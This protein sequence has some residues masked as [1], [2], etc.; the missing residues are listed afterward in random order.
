MQQLYR[1]EYDLFIK[2]C[3]LVLCLAA[4]HAATLKQTPE[5]GGGREG[6]ATQQQQPP[7]IKILASPNG[8]QQTVETVAMSIDEEK[9]Q[10]LYADLHRVPTEYF[11]V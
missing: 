7:P 1:R 10:R 3:N 2:H 4:A 8:S 11:A 5:R 6:K 9:A